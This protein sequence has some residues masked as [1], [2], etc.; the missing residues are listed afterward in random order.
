MIIRSLADIQTMIPGS[1]I[2]ERYT[3][4]MI[5]GVSTDT[6]TIE[7]GNLYVPLK[8]ATFN[9]HQFVK[10]AFDK[11][12]AAALWSKHEPNAPKD[13]PL[14]FVDDT[15]VALQQ[16]AHAYRKQ[17]RTRIIGVTGSNGKTTTKDMIASLLGTVYRVQKTEGNLNNHIGVPLTLLRLKEDTEYAVVEMGMSGF[18]EIELLSTL[19]EPDVAI[20]TN[21]G[22]SHLQELGSREGIATAKFEIVKGLQRGGL[23]IYH[24]DE[25]LLQTRVQQCMLSHV[26]TFGMAKTNDYYPLDIR[27]QADGTSFT[28]NRWPNEMFH[29]PLLGRHHVMNALAAIVVARFAS[30]DVAHMK[31][32]FSRLTVTKMR[33]EVIKRD[34]G[35]T[36]INDAYNAS[37]TSMRAALELLG[38]LTGYRKKIA[39]V[40]DMLELG[41]QEIAFHEQIGEMI[42][43]QSIHYVLTYGTRAKAIAERASERF[44]AGC[45]RSYDDKR[46]LA[47]DVQ[48]LIS[49]GDVILLKA[50]RGMKL[51][52]IISL[53]NE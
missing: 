1:I 13:V 20:I 24:G 22:E 7:R 26:E 14:I 21:I 30:I 37:P 48:A 31:E 25:P 33:T 2:D 51:E 28:V 45:V 38:Q 32:G 27:V 10:E 4:V 46:K 29:M 44:R 41:D 5:H 36:I 50:S 35:V 18:G 15:L 40:G 19:A 16:L 42:D 23:F 39:I 6:R 52:E 49:A 47:A 53:L 3:S 12:A 17:L 43:P 34:D 8:G 9:G 11:G